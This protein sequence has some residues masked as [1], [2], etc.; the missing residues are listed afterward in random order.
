MARDSTLT[1]AFFENYNPKTKLMHHLND[2]KF[3][4]VRMSN[5]NIS[6]NK[7]GTD[8]DNFW[9]NLELWNLSIF[10][11]IVYKL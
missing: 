8:F 9:R 6:K 7:I 10:S 2:L 5:T 4:H 11:L 1:E 3:S